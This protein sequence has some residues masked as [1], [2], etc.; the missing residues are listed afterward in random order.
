MFTY[1]NTPILAI[2][3]LQGPSFDFF[4]QPE[5]VDVDCEV[6]RCGCNVTVAI[7]DASDRLGVSTEC[8]QQ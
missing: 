6:L 2:W 4:R 3:Y 5:F 1:N 7:G 8:T